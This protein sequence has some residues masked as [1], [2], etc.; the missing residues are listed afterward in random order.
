[1]SKAKIIE[2]DMRISS[3]VRGVGNA[4]NVCPKTDYALKNRRVRDRIANATQRVGDRMN[5]VISWEISKNKRI[6]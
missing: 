3:F 5:T 4:I 1:M 2:R 6:A